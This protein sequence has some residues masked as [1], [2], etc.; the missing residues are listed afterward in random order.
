MHGEAHTPA[1]IS[2]TGCGEG[3]LVN[4]WDLK[5]VQVCTE[6]RSAQE[7]SLHGEGSAWRWGGEV[8]GDSTGPAEGVRAPPRNKGQDLGKTVGN[9]QIV[10]TEKETNGLKT[11]REAEMVQLSKAKPPL[12]FLGMKA[13]RFKFQ[14]VPQV[15]PDAL[16]LS[17][18]TGLFSSDEVVLPQMKGSS[19]C[20]GGPAAWAL[21]P[22]LCWS[23][24]HAVGM[25]ASLGSCGFIL[26][27][28]LTWC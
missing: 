8:V 24:L 12:T 23:D 13:L 6:D 27:F 11:D 10:K 19:I 14:P 3:P 4:G 26:L 22:R 25:E 2:G 15:Q 20:A 28:Y 21:S 9:S 18:V 17:V 5:T 16:K 7:T 1:F